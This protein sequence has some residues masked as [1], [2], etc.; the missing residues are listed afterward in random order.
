MDVGS[1]S[2][3]DQVVTGELLD[4]AGLLDDVLAAYDLGPAPVAV[5]H[6]ISENLTYRVE[7]PSSGRRWA[8]RLHRPGYHGAAEIAAEL[9]WVE[10][11]RAE[12][13]VATP[14]VVRNRTGS[15]LTTVRSGPAARHGVLFAWVEGAEPEPGDDAALVSSFG[16]LGDMAGRLHEHARRW[17]RPV[18]FRRFSW[19]WRT[20]LGPAGRWGSWRAGVVDA[21]G[22][23]AGP[24][25][26]VL[27]P[28][29]EA[30]ERR[31]A[32]YGGG[33]DRAGLIHADMRLANLLI[34]PPSPGG[35]GG[36]SSS[37][38]GSGGGGSGGGGVIHLLDFDDCGFG[39]FLYD[40]A[41]AL[42]FIEH[43]P[44]LPGLVGAWLD[45]YQAHRRLAP[46]DRGMVPTLVLL[47][48][49]LLVGWLGTHPHSDAVPDPAAYARDS[50]ELARRYLAGEFL[51][52]LA[53]GRP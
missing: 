23:E 1:G 36:S 16:V 3:A 50:A 40:L 37:G 21:L 32:A 53:S 49:L 39:W 48:R 30:I 29:A 4:L 11:L 20:T 19:S 47:R 31:L 15:A 43:S 52:E 7:D 5:L 41:A 27:E 17:P 51:P 42:S 18:G 25:L 12:G 2:D 46:S 24:V 28:A 13:V 26:A 44:V 45:A 33:A 8:L 34:G 9:A 38:S 10:A 35:S 22:A 6:T 14:P